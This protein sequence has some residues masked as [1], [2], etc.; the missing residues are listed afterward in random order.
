LTHPKIPEWKSRGKR[1]PNIEAFSDVLLKAGRFR[2]NNGQL[3][4]NNVERIV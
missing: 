1:F 2:M 3:Y 4:V